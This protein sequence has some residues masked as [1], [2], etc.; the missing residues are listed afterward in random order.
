MSEGMQENT[1][2]QTRHKVMLV[3]DHPIVRHGLSLLIAQEPDLELCGE[4]S[5]AVETLDAL[6]V[7]M[8]DIILVD[9]SLQGSSGIELT[10]AIRDSYPHLP[11]LILSMHDETLYAERAL[12]SG[13]RG[14]V[15]KQESAETVLRAVRC[16]LGGDVYLSEKLASSLLKEAVCGQRA[17]LD[18]F[19]IEMLSDREL[20]IFELIGRG[21][22]TR[23]IAERL[24][25]SVKTIETHRSHIK[26]K[27]NLTTSAELVHRAFHWIEA[28]AKK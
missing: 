26:Q 6:K 20:E 12:R 19:G 1:E 15:M 18:R 23:T 2:Q 8:P 7:I 10:K 11:V 25:L 5:T 3:D 13:A 9:I 24:K 22:A 16:V 27:L 4:A 28:S 21:M 17:E 14:Y